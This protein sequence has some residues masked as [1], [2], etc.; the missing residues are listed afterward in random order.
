MALRLDVDTSYFQDLLA[1]VN[2]TSGITVMYRTP[3]LRLVQNGIT[4]EILGV[5]AMSNGSPIN[6]KATRAVILTLGGYEN[7]QQMLRDYCQLANE[8]VRG[9]RPTTPETAY[10][11]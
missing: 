3:P 4:G 6:V 10:R 1:Q 8:E 2:K 11:W 9:A 5:Q 7:N